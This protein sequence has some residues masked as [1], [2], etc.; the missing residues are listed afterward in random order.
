MRGRGRGGGRGGDRRRRRRWLR[1]RRR[2]RLGRRRRGRTAV[3]AGVIAL[4]LT[5]RV[6]SGVAPV[7]ARTKGARI[8]CRG[9]DRQDEGQQEEPGS[10]HGG[11]P[12]PSVASSAVTPVDEHWLRLLAPDSG[13]GATREWLCEVGR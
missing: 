4:S 2:R 1:G 5:A 9:R 13:P 6:W 3:I 10:S 7:S 11:R 8:G 12:R